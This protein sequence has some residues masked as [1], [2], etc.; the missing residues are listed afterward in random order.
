MG[1]RGTKSSAQLS[2]ASLELPTRRLAPP[3]DL[4]EPCSAIW[5][6]IV[7]SLPAERFH[8]SDAP[9]LALYCRALFQ[10]RIAFGKLEDEAAATVPS[11]WLKAAEA[12]SKMA[13]LLATKLRLCPQS[14]LDMKVAGPMA[15][16]VGDLRLMWATFKKTVD[17]W[18]VRRPLDCC[19]R[20]RVA[21]QFQKTLHRHPSLPGA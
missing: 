3:T 14:R 5:R 9:L 10:A 2:V 4:P 7:D 17:P 6:S 16:N 15:R 18:I 12:A 19:L 11:Q 20:K 1:I 13:A 8:V 21:R